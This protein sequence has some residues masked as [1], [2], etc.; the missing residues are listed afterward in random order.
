MPTDLDKIVSDLTTQIRDLE[1][2]AK[3]AESKAK[4]AQARADLAV[5]DAD[6][7]IG[8]TMVKTQA[9][10]LE[11][12]ARL[13]PYT[14]KQRDLAEITSRVEAMKASMMAETQRLKEERLR[15]L[16]ELND[17]IMAQSNRLNAMTQQITELK[18][19]VASL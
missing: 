4:D 8:E 19:S 11:I 7:R 10:I 9:K 12:E 3:A 15:C 17:K 5:L 1:K 2:Q 16:G 13:T 6:H 14:Q 18:A